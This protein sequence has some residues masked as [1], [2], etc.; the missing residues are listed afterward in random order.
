MTAVSLEAKKPKMLLLFVKTWLC[1]LSPLSLCKNDAGFLVLVLSLN[2]PLEIVSLHQFITH[3][4]NSCFY[5]II[6]TGKTFFWH[7]NASKKWMFWCYFHQYRW[8]PFFN[9]QKIHCNWSIAYLTLKVACD[10][11]IS[12]LTLKITCDY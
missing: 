9:C 6:K 4:K 7:Q 1:K 5:I 11:S 8:Q 3:K 2:K 12:N 10:W